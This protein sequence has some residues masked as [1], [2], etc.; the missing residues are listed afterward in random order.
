MQEWVVGQLSNIYHIY[1]MQDPNTVKQSLLQVILSLRDATSLPWQAVRGA[2][3]N[4]MHEL[5]QGNLQWGDATQCAL[6][7]LSTS[8]IAMAN[9]S[10]LNPQST[11]KKVCKYYN[12]NSCSHEGNHGQYRHVCVF[13]ARQGKSYTYPETSCH[14]KS[15]GGE[16][17]MQK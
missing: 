4:F 17:N 9:S 3:A 7:R 13:C 2:W 8:Q 14:F 6:N 12:E 1:H 11:T 15:R 16:R 5:E 10:H